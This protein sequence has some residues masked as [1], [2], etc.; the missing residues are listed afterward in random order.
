MKAINND[1]KIIALLGGTFDPPH[2]GHQ[3]IIASFLKSEIPQE[4]WVLPT[5]IPPFKATYTLTAFEHRYNMANIAFSNIPQVQ[6]KDYESQFIGKSFTINTIYKLSQ[7]YPSTQFMLCIGQ[8]NL[9][10]FHKWHRFK[11]ILEKV[12]LLVAARPGFELNVLPSIFHKKCIFVEHSPLNISS[13]I[14]REEL[15]VGM[16]PKDMNRDVY[17][18]IK[19]HSLYHV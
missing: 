4:V 19:K 16:K 9:S 5:P 10:S 18:Y 17:R 6:V 12:T 3:A 1:N 14:I 11:D 15:R 8:D 2:L 13:T 7:D